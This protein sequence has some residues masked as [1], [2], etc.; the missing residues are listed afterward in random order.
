MSNKMPMASASHVEA[1]AVDEQEEDGPMLITTLEV[2][3]IT[4]FYN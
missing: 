3:F 2:K 4:C 1:E